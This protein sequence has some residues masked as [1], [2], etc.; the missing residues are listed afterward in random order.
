MTT[1]TSNNIK[2]I[3][4]SFI[5]EARVLLFGSMARGDSNLGSDYD[6]VVITETTYNAK[7]KIIWQGKLR[8]A[9]IKSLNAPVDLLLNSEEEIRLKRKLPGHVIQYAFTE[10]IML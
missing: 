1:S 10:G 2:E 7:D 9:L 8:K 4:H 6:V 5:P 3:I